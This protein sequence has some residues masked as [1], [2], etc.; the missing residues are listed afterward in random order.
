[1]APHRRAMESKK[2]GGPPGPP[3]FFDLIRCVEGNECRSLRQASPR[4]GPARGAPGF[5]EDVQPAHR[6]YFPMHSSGLM[7]VLTQIVR[8]LT[9]GAWP[10]KHFRRK[11]THL[12]GRVRSVGRALPGKARNRDTGERET[13]TWKTPQAQGG[14]EP[15]LVPPCSGSGPVAGGGPDGPPPVFSS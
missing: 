13:P 3:C 2:A 14:P 5:R 11:D 9:S 10:V 6:H 7:N 12:W 15:G 1:M 4:P 8:L